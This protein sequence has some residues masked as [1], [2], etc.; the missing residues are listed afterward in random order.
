MWPKL[1][2]LVAIFALALCANPVQAQVTPPFYEDL[3][4][5]GEYQ[6]PP[7]VVSGE[8]VYPAEVAPEQPELGLAKQGPLAVAGASKLGRQAIPGLTGW[9]AGQISIISIDRSGLVA[10]SLSG[11]SGGSFSFQLQSGDSLAA[12]QAI[13][14]LLEYAFDSSQEVNIGYGANNEIIAVEISR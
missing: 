14:D 10:V 13:L 12:R 5:T 9:I 8:P 1:I 7:S 2:V 6:Q 3:T 4:D 11:P